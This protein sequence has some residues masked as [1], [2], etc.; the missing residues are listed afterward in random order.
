MNAA[1]DTTREVQEFYQEVA[2]RHLIPLWKVTA[3]LL[4]FEPKTK[5]IPYLWRWS[6]LRRMSYRAGDLVP[7]ER[8]GERRVFR[9]RQS[10]FGRQVCGHAHPLG[11]GADRSTR[12]D[13]SLSSPHGSGDSIYYRRR[14][15]LYERE[16]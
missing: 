15:L 3:R 2:Q 16:R 11:S 1:T 10:R 7:I 5:V 4:P 9:I 14:P 6:D 12:R 8:G 13:R